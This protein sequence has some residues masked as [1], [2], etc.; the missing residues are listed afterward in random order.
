MA[1]IRELQKNITFT[2]FALFALFGHNLKVD[3]KLVRSI[4]LKFGRLKGYNS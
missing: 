1:S 3:F 2:Y 4:E